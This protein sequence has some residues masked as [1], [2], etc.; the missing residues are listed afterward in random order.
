[1]NWYQHVAE[2]LFFVEDQSMKTEYD[3]TTSENINVTRF[4]FAV[5]SQ[6]LN[7]IV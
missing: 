1:M 6:L 3:Q 5:D 4:K 7:S 2:K